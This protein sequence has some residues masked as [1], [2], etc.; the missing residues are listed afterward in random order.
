MVNKDELDQANDDKQDQV[1]YVKSTD[2]KWKI[3]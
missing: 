2:G 3:A 1:Q